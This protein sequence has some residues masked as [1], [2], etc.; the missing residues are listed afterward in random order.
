M[1][2]PNENIASS[3][4]MIVTTTENI[5]GTRPAGLRASHARG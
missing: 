5:P 3:Q 2:A 1:Q 4:S